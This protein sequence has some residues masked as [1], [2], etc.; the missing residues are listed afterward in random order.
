MEGKVKSNYFI[1]ELLLLQSFSLETGRRRYSIG[2]D[3][4]NQCYRSLIMQR[5]NSASKSFLIYED[6]YD[7]RSCERC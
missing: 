5:L 4:N 1:Q 2:I 7:R 3:P 6:V